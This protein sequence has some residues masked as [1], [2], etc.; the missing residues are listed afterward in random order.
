[1]KFLKK[2]AIYYLTFNGVYN[3]NN[4]IGSQTKL[5]LEGIEKYYD[6][7]SKNF[8]NFSLNIITPIYNPNTTMDYCQEYLDY[9]R[10]I[11]K[12]NRRV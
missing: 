4:G 11:V 8:G 5:F 10:S 1:M 6:I 2:R 3:I 9:T 7:F 12:K